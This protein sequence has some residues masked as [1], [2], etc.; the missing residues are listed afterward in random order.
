ML[1][2]AASRRLWAPGY[3]KGYLDPGW[4]VYGLS[5]LGL[6]DR[7]HHTRFLMKEIFSLM[8]FK[9]SHFSSL[10]FLAMDECAEGGARD[11]YDGD[12]VR[13]SKVAIVTIASKVAEH[14]SDQANPPG[15]QQ[16]QTQDKRLIKKLHRVYWSTA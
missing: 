8:A 12:D 3:S 10:R 11:Y 2:G 5:P 13:L 9:L 7:A 16:P 4:C 14:I 1:L 6:Y 15:A